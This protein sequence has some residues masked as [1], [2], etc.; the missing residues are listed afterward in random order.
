MKDRNFTNARFFQ[1]NQLPQIDSQLTAKLD[2]DNS[3]DEPRLVRINRDNDF[4]NCNLTIIN[5]ITSNTQAVN[6][7]Q[8]ISK[9]YV[10]QFHQEN[11]Q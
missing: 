4:N 11:E 3:I 1:V 9:A 5:S 10:D 6:D 7:N 2:V 8:V